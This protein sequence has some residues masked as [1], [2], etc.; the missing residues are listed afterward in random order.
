[1]PSTFRRTYLAH[2]VFV[3]ALAPLACSP[4]AGDGP[5]VSS[6]GVSGQKSTSSGG[7]PIATGG[8]TVSGGSSSGGTVATG[9]AS[10]NG[11][12]STGGSSA[13]ANAT[14]GAGTPGLSSGGSAGTAA[15]GGANSAG[16]AGSGG[17]AAGS[18]GSVAT[19]GATAQ[20]GAASGGKSNAG[21]SAGG[22]GVAT[23]GGKSSTG[24]S[25]GGGAT[26]TGGV[27]S[28]AGASNAGSGNC[29]GNSTANLGLVGYA[30]QNGGT[31]GG[32]GGT[33]VTV[34]TG[35]ELVA[36]L[37]AKQDSTTPLTLVVTGTITPANSGGVE[38]IDVKDVRDVSIIG[39]GAGAEFNGIGIKIVK[40][41]NIVLRNLRIHHVDIGDKDAI[42]IEGPADHV[43]VDHCELYSQY[44]GVD[45]DFYDGLL[46]AKAESEYLT[47]SWNY[48]HDSWKT[49][50]VGS[51]ENDTFDRK[52]T[53]HH[54]YF[55]NCNSRLPLFRGGSAHIFNNYYQDIVETAIN[56]RS[57]AC[58]QIENNYF[59][60]VTNPW[61]SAFTTALGGGEIICNT[62]ADGT[63]FALSDSSEIFALPSCTLNVPY[64]HASFLNLPADVPRL[65]MANAGVGKLADPE[66]F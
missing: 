19:G 23:T 27:P 37:E 34:S 39:A 51:S 35:A 2:G 9:G 24:G 38:K 57:G 28:S 55:K 4:S 60:N 42:S 47:Y 7:A 44:Q 65:V 46:D 6:G 36:A 56:S 18:G 45:K 61:V 25:A 1:M 3:L 31:T 49:S 10:A 15:A 63:K 11:G 41:G 14:G 43:W 48:F 8:A 32:K 13:G 26:S 12:S 54:N 16:K 50:L 22:G 58:V 62:L 5:G 21:G 20:G 59:S 53:I 29:Q 30:T 40:A 52:L 33:R 17:S 64:P 66:S